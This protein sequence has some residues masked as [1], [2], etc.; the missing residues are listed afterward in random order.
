MRV[1]LT[2]GIGSGKSEVA[3]LLESLGAYIIDTDR[4]ARE[5]VAP[6]S[7]GL[8]EIAR[9]WPSVVRDDCL[10]RAALAQI[11]FSDPTA[12]ERLNAIVHPHVRRLAT[13]CERYARVGQPIVHVVPLLFETGYDQRMDATIVV[14]AP[15]AIRMERV[16]RRD[17]LSQAQ[18]RARMSSQIDPG[19]AKSRATYVIS[20][21]GSF[22]DLREQVHAVYHALTSRVA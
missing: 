6:G 3:R 20:N 17:Q 22:S 11:V 10:D 16:A 18:I 8:R 2:G 12:R 5:A 14:I 13:D 9:A 19:V 7:D 15:D 4:L 1:G 21:N